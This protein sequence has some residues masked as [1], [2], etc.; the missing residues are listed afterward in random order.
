MKN[1]RWKTSI[2]APAYKDSPNRHQSIFISSHSTSCLAPSARIVLH[3][4][5]SE[6]LNNYPVIHSV[7]LVSSFMT[8]IKSQCGA[9]SFAPKPSFSLV[10]A[11]ASWWKS[12]GTEPPLIP[13]FQP[14]S[15]TLCFT[16]SDTL[17]T[18]LSD[19][20]LVVWCWSRTVHEEAAPVLSASAPLHHWD[21]K[22]RAAAFSTGGIFI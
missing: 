18:I 9:T 15:M 17:E 8:F 11:F 16:S 7:P 14:C 21:R 20:S 22:A 10:G 3:H 19:I 1:G 2:S 5:T 6:N 4:S 12:C 13:L